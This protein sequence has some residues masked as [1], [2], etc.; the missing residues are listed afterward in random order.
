[1]TRTEAPWQKKREL[2]VKAEAKPNLKYGVKPSERTSENYLLHGV[3]NLDKP[4]GP[5]S[6]EVAAW[7][8]RILKIDQIGHGGTLE[9]QM[10]TREIP[11]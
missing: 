5:S 11:T 7:A 3:I 8:K 9:V 1:M 4:A 6:H 10:L 2:L